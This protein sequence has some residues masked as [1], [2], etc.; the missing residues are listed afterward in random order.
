MTPEYPL[1]QNR[2][3]QALDKIF[4]SE[5]PDLHEQQKRFRE[6]PSSRV[7]APL[8]E[9]YRKLGKLEEAI[10]ICQVGLSYH[11]N[12]YG[13]RMILARCF[14]DRKE[15]EKAR[16]ELENVINVVPENIL[17]QHLLGDVYRALGVVERAIHCY[18][19][20]QMLS[21]ED[22]NL[23]QK[24]KQLESRG[25]SKVPEIKPPV[26]HRIDEEELENLSTE[27]GEEEIDC[28][29]INA[30]LRPSNSGE[31]QTQIEDPLEAF[32]VK[33]VNSVFENEA[34]S[35]A[36]EITTETLAD[37][38]FSQG[39]YEQSMQILEQIYASDPTPERLQKIHRCKARLGV[40]ESALV[41]QKQIDS[42]KS[43]LDRVKG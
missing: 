20:A 38:Y 17:A 4:E 30:A 39:Q 1:R 27:E 33:A 35:K 34:A 37:L 31:Q 2:V 15:F 12:F 16:I 32:S 8:A 29:A 11:P 43:V 24:I 10:D 9:K 14:I 25:N 42:L 7:F 28:P 22:G 41:R 6:D 36:G 21:P 23:S 18:R 19:M 40:D 3:R 13:G 5:L 26:V